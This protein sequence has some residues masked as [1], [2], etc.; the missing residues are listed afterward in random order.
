MAAVVGGL[1]K[2]RVSH[3]ASGGG[4]NLLRRRTGHRRERLRDGAPTLAL[5]A[6]GDDGQAGNVRIV[7]RI[8]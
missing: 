1:D 4:Q 5:P 8:V 7:S 6:V 3:R 2:H